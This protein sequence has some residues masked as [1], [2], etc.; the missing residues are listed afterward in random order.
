MRAPVSYDPITA[1]RA[2]A[3]PA[4]ADDRVI[5]NA[6]RYAVNHRQ[7]WACGFQACDTVWQ[8]FGTSRDLREVRTGQRI[9]HDSG[10]SRRKGNQADP[11]FSDSVAGQVAPTMR[12]TNKDDACNS[13]IG[14]KNCAANNQT[15][16]GIVLENSVSDWSQSL[17]PH[18]LIECN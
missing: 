14:V 12:S 13:R 6:D 2:I 9:Q 1:V 3:F 8:T 11:D 7:R 17:L 5:G 10:K 4:I 15:V 16:A 18:C